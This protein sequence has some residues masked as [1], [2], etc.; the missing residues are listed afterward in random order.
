MKKKEPQNKNSRSR[1][2][3]LVKKQ[4]IKTKTKSVSH[5]K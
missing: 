2:G 3:E 4:T 1:S 5:K